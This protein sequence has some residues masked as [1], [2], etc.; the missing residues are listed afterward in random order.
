MSDCEKDGHIF[1]SWR[2]N[3]DTDIKHNWRRG[4]VYNYVVKCWNC[5]LIDTVRS[6]QMSGPNV[7]CVYCRTHSTT[8]NMAYNIWRCYPCKKIFMHKDTL[9][10][11][12]KEIL[13]IEPPSFDDDKRFGPP[14]I[15]VEQYV[16]PILVDR[17]DKTTQFIYI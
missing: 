17:P 6:E 12:K 11:S 14:S 2:E 5:N 15:G 16:L 10:Y 7:K 4:I 13:G 8:Y 9:F 1:V 3:P